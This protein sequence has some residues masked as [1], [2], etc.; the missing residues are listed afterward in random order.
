MEVRVN[1]SINNIAAKRF[2]EIRRPLPQ[3]SITT[4][5]NLMRIDKV[6]ENLLEVPFVLTVNYNPTIAQISV[7][8]KAHVAGDKEDLKKIYDAYGEKKALPPIIMQAISNVVLM[9][10]LLISR[11]INV[12][13]PIPL[14]TISPVSDEKKKTEPSYRT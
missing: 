1:V 11:T 13:P 7:E 9:E 14:P 5:L 2:E 6:E 4:N 8:G 12:P 3:V 10:S